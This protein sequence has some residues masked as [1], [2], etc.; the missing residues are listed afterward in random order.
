MKLKLIVLSCT[1]VTGVTL[2]QND[3]SE[4]VTNETFSTNPLGQTVITCTPLSFRV[5]TPSIHWKIIESEENLPKEIHKDGREKFDVPGYEEA[6]AK[7]N[8]T[9][10]PVVQDHMGSRQ[11]RAPIVNF[12]GMSGS[13][14]PPDPTGAAG[15]NHYVQAVNTSVRV[16]TKDGSVVPGGTFSLSSLWQG[17]NNMGDPIVLYDRH[18]DRWFI[19]QF[20]ESP[21]RI[22]VAIS[23]TNDPVGDYYE[24]SFTLSQ[25]PDYPKY[26]IWWDGYYMTSN[27][28]HTAVAFERDAMLNGDAG[29]QMVSLSLPSLNNF[30]FK[31]PLPADADGDLPPAGTPC[32]FFNLEDDAFSG[33]SQDQIEIYEMTCD[34]NNTSNSQVVS[35]QILPVGSF[36]SMF[37]GGWSN[38]VQPGTS[39][40]LD[41]IMG[42]FMF[43]AQHMRWTGY[44]TIVLS[45]AVDLGS[46][47]SGVRWYELRDANNGTWSV[48][49]Q[50]TYAPDA[51]KSRWMSSIAMDTWGN[52]GMG[53][54]ISDGSATYPGLA[55]TGRLNG[56]A[57]GTMSYGEQ[58]AFSGSSAQTFTD[59]YGD[60]AH[61]SLD[62]DG[63]TFWYTGEYMG[64]GGSG[65]TRIF[66][67]S[68]YDEAGLSNPY[69]ANLAM[70]VSQ[71]AGNLHVSVEGIHNNESVEL[72]IIS[73]N[74][75]TVLSQKQLQPADG[76][77]SK[78]L[79]VSVLQSGIYFVSV[80]N[81]NF[82]EVERVFIQH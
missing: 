76:K 54:S 29:A 2:G 77:I 79:D 63:K 75:A 44:N 22:L 34:W 5:V 80:G 25:F 58:I 11:M 55:Y 53:Y 36:D 47:R 74:G 3:G 68:I 60:Y 21:N 12:A 72:N 17:S 30:G 14:V 10:D 56:D 81:S 27:S 59:R 1:L 40:G 15:P 28:N 67:F 51:T 16:F 9:V 31:S 41:A 39:Q 4:E 24:Y 52:I 18:A 65:K 78:T 57:L 49:Q 23:K 42:V 32:Y 7:G 19:S 62:P 48:Y 20:Q 37:S 69:Y 35:S 26:S 71:N 13:G 33:V 73:M 50:G 8:E 61:L 6:L 38:I 64:T 45:H 82:Q 43:R 70:I 46:N 66:S